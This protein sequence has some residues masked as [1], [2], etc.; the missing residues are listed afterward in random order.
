MITATCQRWRE[1]R[2]AYRPAREVVATR[3]LDVS[4]IATDTEARAFVEAHHYSRSYPAARFRFGL[5][6]RGHLVGVAVFSVPVN[7]RSLACLPGAAD[8]RVELGR[9]VLLDE[10]GANAESWFVAR[11]FE[12]LEREG[13]AGVVSFSD[14]IARRTAAGD[15]VFVGHVGTVYQALNAVY[16]GR[17]A[18]GTH[19]LLPDGRVLSRRA[20]AKLNTGDCGWRYTAELLVAHGAAPLRDGEDRAAWARA[21]VALVTRPLTHPGNH[22]YAWTLRRRDRAHLPTSRP[23]PKIA[24]AGA[25]AGGGSP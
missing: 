8:E 13:L 4:S 2:A 19:R 9:L 12:R 15:V 1:G 14:D 24:P 16:L 11:C 20:I 3:A 7:A 22:K 6:E 17:G 5:H 21:A 23:Y 18:R 10:V 25:A